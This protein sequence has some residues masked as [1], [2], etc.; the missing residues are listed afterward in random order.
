MDRES[1]TD[2]S[3]ITGVSELA[4]ALADD[5]N[6]CTRRRHERVFCAEQNVKMSVRLRG[7]LRSH[8]AELLDISTFG[9]ALGLTRPLTAERTAFLTLSWGEHRIKDVVCTISN[10]VQTS[11]TNALLTGYRCGVSFRPSSP[12]QLDR[13]ETVE[14]INALALALDEVSSGKDARKEPLRAQRRSETGS[15]SSG[16]A[17]LPQDQPAA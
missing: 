14:K 9:A 16:S 1:I 4:N 8:R 2:V 11:K 13:Q 5:D 10:C 17:P 15:N 12:L 7:E 6:F 3:K